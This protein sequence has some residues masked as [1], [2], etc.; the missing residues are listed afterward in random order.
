MF[1][2]EFKL[3]NWFCFLCKYL[4]CDFFVKTTRQSLAVICY[5]Y[6]ILPYLHN[7]VSVVFLTG[8]GPGLFQCCSI[9]FSY[10]CYPLPNPLR[11]IWNL[12]KKYN[13][14]ILK[15]FMPYPFLWGKMMITFEFQAAILVNIKQPHETP[16]SLIGSRDSDNVYWRNSRRF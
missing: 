8:V 11:K 1:L 9:D 12:K 14:E 5:C 13:V 6:P 10:D 2:P 4:G 7:L 16:C 3:L 15:R